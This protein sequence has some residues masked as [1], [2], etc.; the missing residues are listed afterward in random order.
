[1]QS[2]QRGI[3]KRLSVLFVRREADPQHFHPFCLHPGPLDARTHET[4]TQFSASQASEG[5][6]ARDTHRFFCTPGLWRPQRSRHSSI[7]P[8]PRPFEARTRET[9]R[10]VEARPVEART[11]EKPPQPRT[12]ARKARDTHQFLHMALPGRPNGSRHPLNSKIR[13]PKS[14][15][16]PPIFAYGPPWKAKRPETPTRPQNRGPKSVRH[17]SIFAGAEKRGT[18]TNFCFWPFLEGQTA[19]D[20]HSTPESG[21]R[22][23]WDTHQFLH[24]ALFGRPNGSRHPLNPKIRGPKSVRHPPSF[25]YGPLERPN[26]SRHPLTLFG[27]YINRVT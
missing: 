27:P 13:G 26:G 9:P 14:V 21:A 7:F 2:A 25:A 16:H 5:Q 18:P 8:H 12:G 20:T 22:K 10:P 3:F 17:P 19:R 4:T 15:R 23:T 24:M 1:M 6:N 11:F